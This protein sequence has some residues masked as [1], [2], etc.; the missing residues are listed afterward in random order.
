VHLGATRLQND[1]VM[2]DAVERGPEASF[3]QRSTSGDVKEVPCNGTGGRC[4]QHTLAADVRQQRQDRAKE[5]PLPA[6]T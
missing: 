3:D 2:R 4:Q 6:I 5:T 1:G